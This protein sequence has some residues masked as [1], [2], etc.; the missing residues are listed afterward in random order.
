M[1]T[2]GEN[3]AEPSRQKVQ[4]T[5]PVT[6]EYALLPS[7]PNPFNP[8]TRIEF[9][10]PRGGVVSLVVYDVL[11]REVA[12]LADGYY[13]AGNHSVLWDVKSN[14]SGTYYARFKVFDELGNVKYSRVNKLLLMR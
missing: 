10:L 12:T 4:A 7:Y 6:R 11:G 13:D 1:A 8:A 2:L 5:L 14:A 9:A 3:V